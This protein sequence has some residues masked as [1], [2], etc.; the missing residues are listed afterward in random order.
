VTS[1]AAARRLP[2]TPDPRESRAVADPLAR[3]ALVARA[4]TSAL[5]A[6]EIVEIVVRQGMAGLGAEGGVIA[7]LDDDGHV[8]PAVTVGYSS[9]AIGAFTPL[10]VDM[11][12]PL[13][14][15]AR[16]HQPVWVGSRAEAAARFPRLV[17]TAVGESRAWAAIPLVAN[18]HVL[19][20]LGVSFVT[21][22]DFTEEERL[23][24]QT[25]ADQCA[26]ALRQR[27]VHDAERGATAHP[28]AFR[29]TYRVIFDNSRDAV[30]FTT[31]DGRILAANPASCELF[32]MTEAE[33][34]AAGRAGITDPTDE[35]VMNAVEE[36]EQRGYARAE[37]RM[38]RKDG[39][40]FVADVSSGVFEHGGELRSCVIV[41]DV[42]ERVELLARQERLV[43]ELQEL[44]LIDE[45]TGLRNR[46]GFTI[47]ANLA[48]AVA[49]RDGTPVQLL[50][51]D[52]DG[53]KHV[54]DDHGHPA[55]DRVLQDVA[56]AI[57]ESVRA[58]DVAGRL[59]GDEFVA[60]LH[61]AGTD[62][63]A[64]VVTRIREALAAR[65]TRGTEPVGVSVGVVARDAAH[66]DLSDLL[67]AADRAMYVQKQT[68]PVRR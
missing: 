28:P 1:D 62:D 4:L 51:V 40:I 19:G 58:V 41:R 43:A 59:G 22:R 13:T 14:T 29:D 30:M 55:G 8:I 63:A 17:A 49:D 54:N 10:T 32:G 53:L 15:A 26:L 7:W 45:L 46:R 16:D 11:P 6:A 3:V 20:V 68:H 31:P 52:V 23:F 57:R 9:E 44:A 18:G 56:R 33:I 34:I 61:D 25:L 64:C 21:P 50:F 37:L 27:R 66:R 65:H 42:T 48:L 35:R 24:V 5:D 47:A 38:R 60:L 67:A 2:A 39:S 36:R 12:L